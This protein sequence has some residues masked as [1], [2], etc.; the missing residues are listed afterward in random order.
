MFIEWVDYRRIHLEPSLIV[1][2]SR[3]EKLVISM[4]IT[5]PRVPCY[6]EWSAIS[7]CRCKTVSPRHETPLRRSETSR[8]KRSGPAIA[9]GRIW[10]WCADMGTVLSLD[11]MDISGEHQ[12]DL[13]HSITKTRLSNDGHPLEKTSGQLKGDVE[14]ANLNKDPNYCGSCYGASPPESGY[15]LFYQSPVYDSRNFVETSHWSR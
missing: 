10:V 5:F 4:D 12:T 1:D 7:I 3:G 15:V 14:R 2:R 8:P 9:I 13:E 6:C 11:V